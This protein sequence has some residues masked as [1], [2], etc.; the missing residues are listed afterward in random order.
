MG[1]K[2]TWMIRRWREVFIWHWWWFKPDALAWKKYDW[3]NESNCEYLKRFESNGS[4]KSKT[5]IPT[6]WTATN[7]IITPRS[8]SHRREEL[9]GL[10]LAALFMSPCLPTQRRIKKDTY[11]LLRALD[12]SNET[13]CTYVIF[14][15]QNRSADGLKLEDRRIS[16]T[17]GEK[18]DT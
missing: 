2:V 1:S 12:D 9:Y 15:R 4:K 17:W 11:P 16:R 18:R 14:H 5:D 3:K 13:T 10:G 8:A 7:V 6:G